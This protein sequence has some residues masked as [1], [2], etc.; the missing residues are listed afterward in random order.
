M[1]PGSGILERGS[2]WGTNELYANTVFTLAFANPL[3]N[4]IKW[5]LCATDT[6]EADKVVGAMYLV[7]QQA[8]AAFAEISNSTNKLA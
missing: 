4:A 5:F 7:N 6:F 8:R 2:G 1:E 3:N